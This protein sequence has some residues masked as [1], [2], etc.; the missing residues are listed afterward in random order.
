MLNKLIVSAFL[1]STFI[2][3]SSANDLKKVTIMDLNSKV[4]TYHYSDQTGACINLLDKFKM[5][6]S[7]LKATYASFDSYAYDFH[8]GGAV[9]AFRESS[10][11]S[12]S[13]QTMFETRQLCEQYAFNKKQ[14]G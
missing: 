3:N 8:N 13:V 7:V 10:S 12:Y 2:A 11:Q 6:A 4:M 5:T 9:I 14:Q 1:I